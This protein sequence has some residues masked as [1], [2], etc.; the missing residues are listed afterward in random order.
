[1]EV[2]EG[3]F[4]SLFLSTCMVQYRFGYMGW[5]YRIVC[6][7]AISSLLFVVVVFF[8]MACRVS[9]GTLWTARRSSTTMGR[10]L[11]ELWRLSESECRNV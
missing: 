6:R 7:Q 2:K 1:M 10:R 9:E 3:P 8:T 4:S 11:G 5:R